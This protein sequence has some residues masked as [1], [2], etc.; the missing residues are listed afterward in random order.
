MT[1][2]APPS[3][4]TDAA[5]RGWSE[6]STAMCLHPGGTLPDKLASPPDLRGLYRLCD[7]DDVTHEAVLGPARA[8]T[9]DADRGLPR[10][11]PDPARRHRARL[12]H[13]DVAGRR[14]GADRQGGPTR[15]PL[16]QR[17]G[18]G[19]RLGGRAG[20]GRSGPAPPR[21][22]PQRRDA[23]RAPRPPDPREPAVGPRHAAPAGRPRA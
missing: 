6:P 23:R 13:A 22:G 5:P 3:W 17:P 7:A 2:S 10:G 11:R 1:S 15:L 20:A 12:H 21:R 9:Q 8:H 16:P 19:R 18:R 4:A 14:P